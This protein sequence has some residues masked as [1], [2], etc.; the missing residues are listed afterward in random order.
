M[1]T[2]FYLDE[3]EKK[4]FTLVV[5]LPLS[6]WKKVA[7]ALQTDAGVIAY[8]LRQTI[9]DCVSE[10]ERTFWKSGM[11]DKYQPVGKSDG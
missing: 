9:W 1:T 4:P 5:T 6:E 3:P 8:P 2:R 10:A 7:A 11:E